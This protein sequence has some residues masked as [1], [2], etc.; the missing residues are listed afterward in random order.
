MGKMAELHRKS[1]EELEMFPL[2]F[3]REQNFTS[4]QLHFLIW[5]DFIF[6]I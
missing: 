6:V 3:Q 5:A 4:R 1:V 2:F